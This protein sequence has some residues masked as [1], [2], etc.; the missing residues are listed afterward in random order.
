MLL[1]KGAHMRYLDKSL[2]I[3]M[4]VGLCPA[5][6]FSQT[7]PPQIVWQQANVYPGGGS[8]V[9]FS[10]EGSRLASGGSFVS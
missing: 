9:E 3:M 6:L 5:F 2:T 4:I 7:I 10:P 1:S 8:T